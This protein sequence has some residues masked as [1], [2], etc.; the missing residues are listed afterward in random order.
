MNPVDKQFCADMAD[1]KLPL[2]VDVLQ[3]RAAA[4]AKV[5]AA[6]EAAKTEPEEVVKAREAAARAAAAKK[7]QQLEHAKTAFSYTVQSAEENLKEWREH[8]AA[9]TTQE[10]TLSGLYALR[11]AYV[12]G[13]VAT[14]VP[15]V[16]SHPHH[17][18]GWLE[19]PYVLGLCAS[20]AFLMLASIAH[21]DHKEVATR[22]AYETRSVVDR[23]NLARE[24]LAHAWHSV[25][26]MTSAHGFEASK[27]S[28]I[29]QYRLREVERLLRG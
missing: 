26:D 4:E 10:Q 2:N 20:F 29:E 9:L 8:V 12:M 5:A 28:E 19:I 7:A 13:V 1:E 27:P 15:L 23:R 16:L 6:V 25:H 3:V 14:L 18:L 21:E 22:V 17:W 11:R 24:R